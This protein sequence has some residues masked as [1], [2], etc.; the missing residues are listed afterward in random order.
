MFLAKIKA[1]PMIKADQKSLER[2]GETKEFPF[3]MKV[4]IEFVWRKYNSLQANQ[5]SKLIYQKAVLR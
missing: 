4:L 5:K 1:G 2:T 3:M